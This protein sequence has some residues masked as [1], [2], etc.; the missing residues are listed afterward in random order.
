MIEKDTSMFLYKVEGPFQEIEKNWKFELQCHQLAL[1]P[2]H[3]EATINLSLK[4]SKTTPTILNGNLQIQLF[5]HSN[6][7]QHYKI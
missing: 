1:N 3:I 7:F 5:Q 4:N 6:S 2:M